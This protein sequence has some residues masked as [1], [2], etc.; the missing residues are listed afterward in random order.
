MPHTCLPSPG[1]V[2]FSLQVSEGSQAL[3]LGQVSVD[4]QARCP[5]GGLGICPEWRAVGVLG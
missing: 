1:C 4:T 5:S 2:F 3:A